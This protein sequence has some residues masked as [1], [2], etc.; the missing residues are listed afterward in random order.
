VVD[1]RPL[2]EGKAPVVLREG[3]VPGAEV[4]ALIAGLNE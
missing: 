1:L 3:K 4:L 2:A